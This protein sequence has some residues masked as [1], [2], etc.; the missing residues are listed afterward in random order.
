MPDMIHP[1]NSFE[2]TKNHTQ[3]QCIEIFNNHKYFI[4]YDSITFLSVIAALCGCITIVKKVDGLSK[5]DWLNTTCAANYLKE[6]GENSLYGIAYGADDLENAINTIHMASEQCKRINEF[7]KKNY[8]S[9]FIEDVNN[10]ENMINTIE[11][12]FY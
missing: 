6:S 9:K 12:N 4:S 1:S 3:M 5:Y 11:N 7:S 8:I 2:I 10:W